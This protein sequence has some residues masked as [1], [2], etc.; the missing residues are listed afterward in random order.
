MILDP[1]SKRIGHST[2]FNKYFVVFPEYS[3]VPIGHFIS[4]FIFPLLL[5]RLFHFTLHSLLIH[6]QV[7]AAEFVEH[8]SRS[9]IGLVPLEQ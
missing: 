1:F 4:C 8:S 5:H 9:V 7:L 3:P 6:F 2:A